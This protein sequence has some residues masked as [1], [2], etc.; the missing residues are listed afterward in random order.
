MEIWRDIPGYENVYQ[1]SSLGGV[2]SLDHY[3][4]RYPNNKRAHEVLVK[5][6]KLKLQNDGHGYCVVCLH[7]K[8]NK[9]VHCLIAETF[10]GPRPKNLDVRH[11]DG[12]KL[13]NSVG[14]LRYGTRAEN[15]RD[16]YDYGS[17]TH[18][19]TIEQV[20]IIRDRLTAG[21]LVGV[22]AREFSVGRN[23][24]SNIKARRTFSWL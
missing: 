5:G 19:F 14:N 21:E 18:V 17:K 15:N 9:K 2:R 6:K 7:G 22:L 3:A 1:V 16:I 4:L 13:N 23:T 12:N 24:I 20:L 10:L 11:I 8:R